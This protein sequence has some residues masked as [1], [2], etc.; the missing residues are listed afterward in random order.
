MKTIQILTGGFVCPYQLGVCMYIKTH[1]NL[2]NVKFIGGG[3]GSWLSIYMA[4]DM[5]NKIITRAFMPKLKHRFETA[6][7]HTKWQT[8]GIFLKNEIPRYIKSTEFVDNKQITVSLSKFDECKLKTEMTEN[9]GTLDGLLHLCYLSS[10]LS[11]IDIPVYRNNKF[12]YVP[13]TTKDTST[14]DLCV[15]P[16]M[17]GRRF[18]LE[19]YTGCDFANKLLM[20]GYTDTMNNSEFID[21]KLD[22]DP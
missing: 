11:G 19:E 13:F 15:Y 17:W 12:I 18:K 10:F 9:Y 3:G 2:N 8:I 21:N 14:I 20:D 1:Y 4:S 5:P 16:S 22:K 7:L 6:P